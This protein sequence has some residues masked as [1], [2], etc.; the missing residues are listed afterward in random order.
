VGHHHA[1]GLFDAQV[2]G[3]VHALGNMPTE[4]A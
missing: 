4:G 3:A 2:K 1:E